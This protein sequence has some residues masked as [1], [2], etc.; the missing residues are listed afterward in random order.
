[1]IWIPSTSSGTTSRGSASTGIVTSRTRPAQD[2]VTLDGAGTVHLH[3]TAEIRSAARVRESPNIW[4]MAASTRSPASPSGTGRVRWSACVTS[5]MHPVV[6]AARGRD[7]SSRI[8]RNACTRIITAATSMQMSATLKIGQCGSSRKS[9]TCPCRKPGAGRSRSVRLPQTPASSSP[10]ATAHR[11]LPTPEAQPD[12]HDA[13]SDRQQREQQG[14]A[15]AG[16][17]RRTGVAT[18]EVQEASRGSSTGRSRSGRPPA[19]AATW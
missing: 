15:G 4:A 18:V 6:R 7:P 19:T 2:S 11:A 14:V 12:H 3:Q 10:R 13:A 8:P 5:R 9:T 1:M 17:E 16:A